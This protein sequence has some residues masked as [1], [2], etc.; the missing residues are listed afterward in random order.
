MA[1]SDSDRRDKGFSGMARR[2][3]LE[4][5][6]GA[7]RD[8]RD[9][10]H[11]MAA[12][13]VGEPNEW[14]ARVVLALTRLVADD[15]DGARRLLE[16]G[17]DRWA[18]DLGLEPLDSPSTATVAE[19]GRVDSV[20]AE[21]L[22]RAFA[23]AEADVEQMVDVNRVAARVLMDEPIDLAELSGEPYEEDEPGGAFALP[24][25]PAGEAPASR[26]IVLATL[27]RWLHNLEQRG[28][29]RMRGR[30]PAEH[31]ASPIQ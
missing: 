2:E 4:R 19:D 11:A 30:A 26:A 15:V 22:D 28:A 18:L 6:A 5:I 8:R 31:S 10:H 27:E 1:G 17:L 13:A 14:P 20:D 12:A 7:E 9:G 24:A 29:R 21:E 25:E 3:R 23:E 16:E